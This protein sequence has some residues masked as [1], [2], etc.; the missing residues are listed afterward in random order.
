MKRQAESFLDENEDWYNPKSAEELLEVAIDLD[1]SLLS[2]YNEAKAR[3]RLQEVAE[4]DDTSAIAAAKEAVEAAARARAQA[5]AV[6]APPAAVPVSEGPGS[7]P[8]L[9]AVATAMA[10]SYAQRNATT[11]LATDAALPSRASAPTPSA[12][13]QQQPPSSA[14]G[15]PTEGADLLYLAALPS[16]ASAPTPSALQQQPPSS[17]DGTPTE[18]ADL[19]DVF[20]EIDRSGSGVID[21]RH[22]CSWWKHARASNVPA[23]PITDK[24][25]AAAKLRWLEVEHSAGPPAQANLE[26]I[27]GQNGHA[28]C[29]GV[30]LEAFH[31]FVVKMQQS[32]VALG[33]AIY[34]D[35]LGGE[36]VSTAA[37]NTNTAAEDSGKTAMPRRPARAH[38]SASA[39]NAGNNSGGASPDDRTNV[40]IPPVNHE[41]SAR[42]REAA[43]R[44][45][46]EQL[47]E[48]A[49][50]MMNA[51]KFADAASIYETALDFV[52]KGTEKHNTIEK[53]RQQASR[54]A[55]ASE[56]HDQGK[57]ECD[58]GAIEKAVA[59]LSEAL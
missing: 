3:V 27:G 54:M 14:D 50:S 21:F 52:D 40:I 17:A 49:K 28:D 55:K 57:H 41:Q 46:L 22:F 10:A 30:D 2:L 45:K 33:I 42:D 6:P 51:R 47:M 43:R 19:T 44:K 48:Q 11:A 25:F 13:Q 53:K 4:S 20:N 7:G 58:I 35:A 26:G 38:E 18:G 9:D 56:L 34:A 31:I 12:L 16:R 36:A 29:S 23:T 1:P 15:T 8:D 59:T 32:G 5:A 24:E 37:Q 39:P